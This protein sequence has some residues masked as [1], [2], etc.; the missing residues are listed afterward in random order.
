MG[1]TPL[2]T[3]TFHVQ[4]IVNLLAISALVAGYPS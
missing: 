1:M 4:M 3:G 2:M